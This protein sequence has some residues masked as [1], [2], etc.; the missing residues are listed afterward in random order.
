[1]AES[2]PTVSLLEI[3]GETAADA[4]DFNQQHITQLYSGGDQSGRC[5]HIG[6]KM[7]LDMGLPDRV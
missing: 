6:K 4:S 1:V 7:K 5:T 2:L 3:P